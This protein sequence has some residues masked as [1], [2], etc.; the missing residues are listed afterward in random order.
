MV[1]SVIENHDVLTQTSFLIDALDE[2][3]PEPP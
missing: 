3:G 2:A 1:V